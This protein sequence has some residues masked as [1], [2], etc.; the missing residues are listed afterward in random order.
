MSEFVANSTYMEGLAGKQDDAASDIGDAKGDAGNFP[1]EI[2]MTHGFICLATALA[3]KDA[4]AARNNAFEITQAI[5][6]QLAANIRDASKVY[7]AEDEGSANDLA[8]QI[9]SD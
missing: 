1:Y 3:A 4:H 8:G 7:T 6:S 2:V 9:T 5:S